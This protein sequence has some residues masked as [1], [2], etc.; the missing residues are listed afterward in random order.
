[1]A[2]R[3]GESIEGSS[4]ITTV[5]VASSRT[6]VCRWMVPGSPLTRSRRRATRDMDGLPQDAYGHLL[7]AGY[8]TRRHHSGS[9]A[10]VAPSAEGSEEAV[11]TGAAASTETHRAPVNHCAPS[12]D[13]T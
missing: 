13:Q 12:G 11:G 9:S 1:M 10:S 2:A 6:P 4:V 7:V 5:S 3:Q 8:P